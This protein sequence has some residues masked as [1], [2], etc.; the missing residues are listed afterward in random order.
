MA[1]SGIAEHNEARRKERSMQRLA[2]KKQALGVWGQMRLGTRTC[3]K[4]SSPNGP[5][6]LRV[7][8]AVTDM[9][10]N[11]LTEC[12]ETSYGKTKCANIQ[13]R[14][15]TDIVQS[16]MLHSGDQGSQIGAQWP[17]FCKKHD[18]PPYETGPTFT[19]FF[20]DV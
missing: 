18:I 6:P 16:T 13:L 4:S 20:I 14:Y 7:G 2:F 12:V 17:I 9:T 1:A 15:L 8:Q 3:R 10:H 5:D 19:Y 11:M